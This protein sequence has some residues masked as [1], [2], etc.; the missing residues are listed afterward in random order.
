MILL[1]GKYMEDYIIGRLLM[2]TVALHPKGII[3]QSRR[4]GMYFL[5]FL[6][7]RILLAAWLNRRPDGLKMVME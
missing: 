6:V 5:N 1:M 3:Y 4:I 2:M 7:V